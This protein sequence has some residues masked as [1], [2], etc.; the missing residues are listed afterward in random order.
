ME[1]KFQE[2]DRGNENVCN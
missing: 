1:K 2:R